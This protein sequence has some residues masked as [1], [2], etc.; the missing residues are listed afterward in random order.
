MEIQYKVRLLVR[1][2]GPRLLE[3][4]SEFRAAMDDYL[5]QD[6]ISSG[7]MNLLI[8]AVRLDA[9]AQLVHL[10]NSGAPPDA[11]VITA[12]DA[13]SEKRGGDNPAGCRWAC[14]C[15]GFAASRIDDTTLSRFPYTR[16]SVAPVTNAPR[17]PITQP[18]PDG[19]SGG[20]QDDGDT[21]R[22]W[23]WLFAVAA[24]LAVALG[25][26]ALALELNEDG[27]PPTTVVTTMPATN[28][29]TNDA[30]GP[31]AAPDHHDDEG[32]APEEVIAKY[33]VLGDFAAVFDPDICHPVSQLG[34]QAERL[35][36]FDQEDD[37][38]FDLYLT[39]YADVAAL[40]AA[41]GRLPTEHVCKTATG[42]FFGVVRNENV[43]I[44]WDATEDLVSARV[45]GAEHHLE[46][47]HAALEG[48]DASIEPCELPEGSGSDHH[49]E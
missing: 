8:D 40:Q 36:C 46:D 9:Y 26:T 34:G 3:D 6:D 28:P 45:T 5:E 48:L 17:A 44:Y 47:I 11:A 27:T 13:L 29:T 18:Q 15:L 30:P 49:D 37:Q 35:G 21:K 24:V 4:S 43:R 42:V 39:Q 31:T 20:G 7:E 2:I 1:T 38:E 19:W 22:S 12:G 33:A 16:T 10:L 25:A 14:A 41:R 23:M 32:S